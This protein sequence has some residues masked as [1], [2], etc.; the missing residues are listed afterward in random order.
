MLTLHPRGSGFKSEAKWAE[1]YSHD[2]FVVSKY[3]G[4][5]VM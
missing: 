5:L 2:H 1:G 3:R 4:G